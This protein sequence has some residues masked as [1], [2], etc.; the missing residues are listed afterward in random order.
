LMHF[1][2]NVSVKHH[3]NGDHYSVSIP[4]EIAQALG[5]QDG[6]GLVSIEINKLNT[7]KKGVRAQVVLKSY[8]D[9][10]FAWTEKFD[11]AYYRQGGGDI[12]KPMVI[13]PR[14]LG[15]SRPWG[16]GKVFDPSIIRELRAAHLWLEAEMKRCGRVGDRKRY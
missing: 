4:S 3:P 12:F 8:V 5:L 16:C 10:D 6:G 15:V 2:R 14:T 9:S 7:H 13:S 11:P 1:T